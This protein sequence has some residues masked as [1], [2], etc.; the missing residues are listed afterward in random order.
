MLADDSLSASSRLVIPLLPSLQKA[1]SSLGLT[2]PPAPSAR[3]AP[4]IQTIEG[5]AIVEYDIFLVGDS[6]FELIRETARTIG[7]TNPSAETSRG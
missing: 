2:P 5:D 1:F 4:K 3:A 6:H 7:S